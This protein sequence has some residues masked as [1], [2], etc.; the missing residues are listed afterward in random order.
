MSDVWTDFS[1]SGSNLYAVKD[2][3][4]YGAGQNN[5]YNIGLG[6][7]NNQTQLS[8]TEIPGVDVS[9]INTWQS[10]WGGFI[11]IKNNG[12]LWGFGGNWKGQLGIGPN[13]QIQKT[14]NTIDVNED[15]LGGINN[16][17]NISDA[18]ILRAQGTYETGKFTTNGQGNDAVFRINTDG[19][20]QASVTVIDGGNSFA[21]DELITI[22]NTD[23]GDNRNRSLI[24]NGDFEAGNNSWIIGVNNSLPAPVVTVDD[25]TYYSEN[26]TTAGDVFS[27]NVSQK[28]EI[29]NGNSYTLTFDAW[30][31]R[32]RSIV[33]GIGLSKAPYS[34]DIETINIGETRTTFTLMLDATGFGASDGRVLFDIG[35]EV[36][37][38]N[39]DNVS[40]IN[41]NVAP[42]L[43]F[44]V[45]V[46]GDNE[47]ITSI[48]SYQKLNNDTDWLQIFD[49]KETD[50]LIVEKN[51]GSIWFAG[52]N[53]SS[54]NDLYDILGVP[55]Y[56][57]NGLVEIFP[58]GNDWDTFSS[59]TTGNGDGTVIG[60]KDDGTM[61]SFGSNNNGLSGLGPVGGW[62][63]EITQIGSDSDWRHIN[64]NG[65]TAFAIKTDNT[66]WSWG[67]GWTGQLGNGTFGNVSQPV[68]V[69]GDIQWGTTG[70]GWLFQTGLTADGTIY[71]WGYN[72]LGG[73][74]SLGEV[75]SEYLDWITDISIIDGA[76][77]FS[78]LGYV[79]IQDTDA[80][81]YE[82]VN[83]NNNNNKGRNENYMTNEPIEI[84]IP[85]TM[86]DGINT[87][88][89]ENVIFKIINVNE[90]PTDIVINTLSFDENNAP[91]FQLSNIIITDPD[92][93]DTHTVEIDNTY[94]DFNKFA[95]VENYITLS[96]TILYD[97]YEQLELKLNVTDSGGLIY[98]ETF[99][100]IVNAGVLEIDNVELNTTKIEIFPNPF[101]HLLSLNLKN[102]KA[103]ENFS[104]KIFDITG[105]TILEGKSNTILTKINTENLETGLYFIKINFDN[106]L[107]VKRLIKE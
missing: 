102:R 32:N 24:T 101:H 91:G 5:N 10:S 81:D 61:W 100:I 7:T 47:G 64:I 49:T 50:I 59:T 63:N 28:T 106:S 39:I 18:N 19:N 3:K 104:F 17:D 53:N 88:N 73:L 37:L 90:A 2:N 93:N 58:E 1:H 75:S 40:L 99:T 67:D 80:I 36:G 77:T 9:E 30:S 54:D 44:Q 71:G 25:N 34:N 6:I 98:S 82:N 89:P 74:G 27:V 35:G 56:N 48:P 87:S 62:I 66:L 16:I 70:G 4:L 65:P 29:I 84:T 41:N 42:D 96:E 33:A 15:G 52:G 45:D 12:E 14:M 79:I 13:Q 46:F 95:V 31:D 92:L 72:R 8:M 103:P 78:D 85:M 20:G 38:V 94:G 21:E 26:V 68:L 51:N 69:S 105:K 22:S 23:L 60:I 107:Y 83:N 97:A 76:F 55:E 57:N 43:T 86:S 11:S